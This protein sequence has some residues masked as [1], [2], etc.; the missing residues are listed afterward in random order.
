MDFAKWPSVQTLWALKIP[1]FESC[2]HYRDLLSVRI[3]AIDASRPPPA[4]ESLA[5]LLA[6]KAG[7]KKLSVLFRILVL[8]VQIGVLRSWDRLLVL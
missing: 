5:A 1:T 8:S 7:R 2:L 6:D 4:H 3:V